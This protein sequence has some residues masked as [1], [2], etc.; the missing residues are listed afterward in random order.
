MNQHLLHPFIG[1]KIQ[2]VT[3]FELH[4]PDHPFF[5]EGFHNFD[6]GIEI[7]LSNGA[8]W[9]IA[10]RNN[11][12]PEIDKGKYNPEKYHKEFKSLD[13]TDKWS[14]QSVS[15][16]KNI[17]LIYVSEEW[18]I[19][20]QCTIKFE[21]ATSVSIVLGEELNIDGS[22][23]LPLNYNDGSEFYVFHGEELPEIELIQII[24]PDEYEDVEYI[25]EEKKVFISSQAFL[26]V[27]FLLFVLI[28]IIRQVVID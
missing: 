8:H 5:F 4:D 27:I 3:Y 25:H 13:V 23:P 2:R 9:H 28:L 19:P 20:A 11:D 15:P 16:I 17:D 10:W 6:L 26:M 14:E 22:L 7:E 1:Q 21:N 18:K 24:L 12:R